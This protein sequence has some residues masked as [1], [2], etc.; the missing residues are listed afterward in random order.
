MEYTYSCVSCTEYA[1]HIGPQ[2][3][4]NC[5]TELW[6]ILGA[7]GKWLFTEEEIWLE[8]WHME[9]DLGSPVIKKLQIKTARRSHLSPISSARSQTR[10]QPGGLKQQGSQVWPLSP[11]HWSRS[12]SRFTMVASALLFLWFAYQKLQWKPSVS[13]LAARDPECPIFPY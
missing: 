10:S 6:I 7:Q 13:T 4:W 11:P 8:N 9:K 3:T 1:G 5:W 12:C 2:S